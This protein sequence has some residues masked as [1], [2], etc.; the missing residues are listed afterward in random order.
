MPYVSVIIPFEPNPKLRTEWHP[1][2]AKGPFNVL[3]RGV[4]QD[5]A[6]AQIW[7][8]TNLPKDTKWS[9]KTYPS[10]EEN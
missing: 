4:F 7:V 6:Q 1:T 10:P 2:S 3:S 5:E 8:D 9:F